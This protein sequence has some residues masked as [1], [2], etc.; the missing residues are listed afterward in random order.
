MEPGGEVVISEMERRLN[1]SWQGWHLDK[2][3]FVLRHETL[4]ASHAPMRAATRHHRKAGLR[5]ESARTPP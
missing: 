3:Q 5:R 4:A 1:S 2:E